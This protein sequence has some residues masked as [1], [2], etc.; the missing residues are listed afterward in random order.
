MDKFC[1]FVYMLMR[2]GNLKQRIP[3]TMRILLFGVFSVGK[4]CALYMG[5]YGIC[6]HAIIDDKL[7]SF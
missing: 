1:V 5:K 7:F 6:G 2:D 4:K 3:C